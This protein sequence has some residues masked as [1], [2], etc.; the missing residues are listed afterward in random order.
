MTRPRI[1]GAGGRSGGGNQTVVVQAPVYNPAYTADSPGL[2]STSFAQL[3]FLICEGEIEGPAYGNTV[4]GLERSVYLDNTPIRIGDRVV[5]KP[6]DLVFTW[7]RPAAAQTGVP[8]YGTIGSVFGVDKQVRYGLPVSQSVTNPDPSTKIYG[9]VILTFEALVWSTA[10]GDVYATTVDL[11]I[12]SEDASG[13]SRT[14]FTGSVSGKF[15]GAFQKEYEFLLE[16]PGP[17]RLTVTRNTPDDEARTDSVN[18]YRSGF[19]FSTV[20]TAL[21]QRLSY[22]YSS[23]LTLGIRADQY[24]SLPAVSIDLLGRRIQIPINYNPSTRTYAGIWDGTFKIAYSNNPAWILYDIINNERFGLGAFI[25]PWQADKWT[26]YSIGQYCDQQVPA[27]GGGTEPRFT[28]NI[29]L[30]T[31]EQAWTVLQQLSS[32][33]RGML[34][35]SGGYIV[36]IQDSPKV[37]VFTFNESNTIEQFDSD[38]TV[39]SGN[40]TYA[41]AAKRAR[42][43]VVLASWDDPADNFQPRVEYIADEAGISR[44]GYKPLDLRLLGVTSRGQ[45][46][47]AANAALLSE[48]VLDDTVTFASNE[49]G[50]AVRPGD[51]VKIADPTKAAVRYGGRIR[52]VNGTTITLDAAP[53]T[54][55][56]G[57]SGATFSFMSSGTDDQPVLISSAIVSVQGDIVQIAPPSQAPVATFPWLIEVP[58]RTAQDFR[59]LTVEEQEGGVYAF[60]ALRYREDIYAAIDQGTPLN[61]NE[62]YLFTQVNPGTPTITLARVSW[63][64]GQ[65]KLDIEW[66]P[67]STNAVLNGFDLSVNEYRLQYQAGSLQADG[68]ILYD[69]VW[70]DAPRQQDNREQ[71][72]INQFV[73]SDRFLVRVCAV[74]RIGAES[75]WAMR[76]ADDLQV[77]FPMPDLGGRSLDGS[78][79]PSLL[80]N[81]TLSHT[82]QSTGAQLF[83]W[84]IRAPLPPY[85][86]GIQLSAKPTRELTPSEV[87]GAGDASEDGWYT[88]ATLSINNYAALTFHALANWQVRAQLVTAIPGLTGATYVYDFVDKLELEPPPPMQ[89][90]VVTEPRR[91]SAPS[92]RRFSWT[93]T[94]QPPIGYNWP[95]S[96]VTDIAAFDVRFK[97]GSAA[98]VNGVSA[99]D[100]GFPLFSDGIAGDQ[101]WFETSL[102]DSDIWTVMIRSRDQTGWLSSEFA[103]VQVNLGDALPTNVVER[104]DLKDTGFPGELVNAEV[105]LQE[106]PSFYIKPLEETIYISSLDDEFYEGIMGDVLI[107]S[108]A[109][110]LSS[111]NYPLTLNSNS[112]GLIVYVQSSGTYQLFLR[113]VGDSSNS[114]IYATPVTTVFYEAPVTDYIYRES[115]SGI[116]TD[117]HPLAPF[118]R[119]D[120]GDYELLLRFA[121]DDGVTPAII[122]DIDVVI[123]YPDVT[124]TIN[125]IV[126][127]IGGTRVTLTKEFKQLK[128]VSLT[129]QDLEGSGSAASTVLRAKD[130]RGFNVVCRDIN[131]A[132]VEGLVDATCIGY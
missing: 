49:I 16:G 92:T 132:E 2:R 79:P 34:Y 30:Q 25:E 86:S 127:P 22:P 109:T 24:S 97:K 55:P 51:R 87:V 71:I 93:I 14:V 122:W 124:E 116:S 119:V 29:I 128:A 94:D 52:A 42:H 129:L 103:F 37:P 118:E 83:S 80:P 68:S 62:S 4:E 27:A 32:I 15:S 12:T 26:L 66:R 91:P 114:L 96:V 130:R 7:G 120:A 67:S 19:N 36:S 50:A 74:S 69:G 110:S 53:A 126:V 89:F 105:T 23:T 18:T 84:N 81:A 57:W 63:D 125:D 46:L 54:P 33:F 40:F 107:Q 117:F 38:G 72:P 98:P 100:L 3:Q 43:T 101:R 21:D 10:K 104:L 20:V 1:H 99:W 61:D 5:P 123:D 17:W 75:E 70:R 108:E 115:A 88:L 13:V 106:D 8:G 44:F 45:A 39:S 82:N 28:C 47:R 73:A 41:G 85:V 59:I 77:W 58:D 112:A 35:Y 121:S 9:R 6:A 131:G 90:A 11:T 65:A 56:S 64:N 31:A 113:R 60:S 78:N 111:Y 48:A 76:A 102:F 95:N